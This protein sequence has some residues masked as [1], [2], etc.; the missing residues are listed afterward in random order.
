M[1][2]IVGG[3]RALQP[4]P[5]LADQDFVAGW[6]NRYPH[7]AGSGFREVWELSLQHNGGDARFFVRFSSW[8]APA[9]L[10]RLQPKLDQL[11][12]RQITVAELQEAVP[13]INRNVGRAL[14]DALGQE[15]IRPAF[16]A[17]INRQLEEFTRGACD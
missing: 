1:K 13:E 6:E 9:I 14:H 8:T 4:N 15:D 5:V 17:V 12:S 10:E 3:A 7:L 2:W 11:W 16:R